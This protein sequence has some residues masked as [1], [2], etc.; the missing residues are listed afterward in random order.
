MIR[1][2]FN[3]TDDLVTDPED[4]RRE[5]YIRQALHG[6]GYPDWA[7]RMV[8]HPKAKKEEEKKDSKSTSGETKPPVSLPYVKRVLE[9]LRRVYAQ[10]VKTMRVSTL[11]RPS[12]H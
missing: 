7:I 6:C 5:E 12:T 2:L 1:T 9:E 8:M 10:Y 3:R 4:R 11:V